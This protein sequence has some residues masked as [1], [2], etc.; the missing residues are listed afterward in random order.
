VSS[1]RRYAVIDP[2][3]DAWLQGLEAGDPV[4]VRKGTELHV[5]RVA[6][7]VAAPLTVDPTPLDETKLSVEWCGTLTL[8]DAGG[9]TGGLALYPIEP[10][11]VRSADED[12]VYE[13]LEEWAWKWRPLLNEWHVRERSNLVRQARE[14]RDEL[15][16]ILRDRVTE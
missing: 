8:F 10:A 12:A 2:S 16:A 13:A 4:F 1:E 5:G 6:R 14:I 9:V 15:D 7:R 11:T 3:R